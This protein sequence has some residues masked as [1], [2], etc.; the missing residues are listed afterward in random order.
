ME[1]PRLSKLV[2]TQISEHG[3]MATALDIERCIVSPDLTSCLD[4][5]GVNIIPNCWIVLKEDPEN[6]TGYSI[7]YD[8]SEGQFALAKVKQNGRRICLSYY[9]SFP[10]AVEAM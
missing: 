6:D 5:T 2:R 9:S 1:S 10:E 3:P 8:E 4:S 7:V